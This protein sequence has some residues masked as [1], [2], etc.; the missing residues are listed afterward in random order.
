MILQAYG[1]GELLSLLSFQ[2]AGLY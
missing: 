1:L 2:F